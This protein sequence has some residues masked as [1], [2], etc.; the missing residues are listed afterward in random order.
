MSNL[1]SYP[2]RG[3]SETQKFLVKD[4]A[5]GT[6]SLVLGSDLVEYITPNLNY[7]RAETT[8]VAAE[9][10][11]YPIGTLIQT[12]GA[13]AIDDNLASVY[14]VVAAGEGDFPM[15]NGNELLVIAGD[16]FLRQQLASAA[17]G[18]GAS[19]V[20]MEGGPSV[21]QAVNERVI[22]VGSVAEIEG[23]SVPAGYVF[24]LNSGNR[25]GTFDVIAGDFSAE[26]A[27]DTLNG[28][29]IG[30]ADDP[31][32][33]TK[34]AKRR[35]EDF[36][37]GHFGA[38]YSG[39]ESVIGQASLDVTGTLNVPYGKV[40]TCKNINVPDNAEIN[41]LGSAVL[42][43][44]AA[45]F[46][47]IFYGYSRSGIKFKAKE[48][49][50]NI[51]GQGGTLGTHLLYF[52][53]CSDSNFD[54]DYA[55]D[56]YYV[57]G[58]SVG[59][60]DGGNRGAS[61][62]AIYFKG[63]AR[64]DLNVKLL[65]N[66]GREGV[67]LNECDDCNVTLGHA[68]GT[69]SGSQYSGVQVK[70]NRNNLHRASVDLAKA[71]GIGFDTQDG[72]ASNILSTNTRENHGLN[73]GHPGFP[74]SRSAIS[75]VVIDTS[76]VQGIQVSSGTD[77]L[78]ISNFAVKNSGEYGLVVS[79]GSQSVR[80]SNGYISNSGLR[81][82]RA[83]GAG[84]VIHLDNTD[85]S[86]LNERSVVANSIVGTFVEGETI[87]TASSSGV[88]QAIISSAT[89]RVF[90][91]DSVTGTFST[92]ETIT[93]S[94]SGATATVASS[95]QPGTTSFDGGGLVF[96]DGYTAGSGG[97]QLVTKLPN[98]SALMTYFSEVTASAN[99]DQSFTFPYGT[100][101]NWQ[102]N[103]VVQATITSASSTAGY[104]VERLEA[105]SNTSEI[106]LRLRT[107]VSQSYGISFFVI[108]RYSG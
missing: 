46:D 107:T 2:T 3:F 71:S 49:D 57:A 78:S 79:D 96:V 65:S 16:D 103:P 51:S 31:S 56:H 5:T 50:G 15:I 48:L 19:L 11:D 14:L 23:Y 36:N 81:N 101:I 37:V 22:R 75:N 92:G 76:R 102:E 35:G 12:A 100:L 69:E 39:D 106:A 42:P 61:A 26:L 33:A 32:A 98:G 1:G 29:Y 18:E 91:L 9:N 62:G 40:F 74:A 52:I 99:T 108:G 27:Q 10:T 64:V 38:T 82:A 87:T 66:W 94:T 44:G 54:I 47:K 77:D 55:H 80:L 4:P 93:G 83:F 85:I 20:S 43:G 73:F 68:Q 25:S 13:M 89:D 6:A 90:L 21:E 30:L 63:A 7:V 45:D 60:T 28:V 59:D 95:A 17:P 104:T 24:S 67:F 72:F 58:G 88:V 84:A 86:G 53:G 41:I 70:G 34:V 8:R 105:S 97:N